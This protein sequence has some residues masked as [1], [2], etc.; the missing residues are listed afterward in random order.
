MARYSKKTYD[1]VAAAPMGMLGVQ[2]GAACVDAQIPVQVIAKWMGVSRQ[3][4]YYWFTGVTEVAEKHQTKM[5]EI[6]QLLLRALKDDTLPVDD[7]ADAVKII[8]KY[9]S[10]K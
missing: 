4:V 9:R 8:K 2:F 6:R 10:T 7:L 3:G 5:E 1:A